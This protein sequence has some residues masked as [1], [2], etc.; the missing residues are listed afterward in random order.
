M[1]SVAK[2]ARPQRRRLV[3]EHL[4]HRVSDERPVVPQALQLIGM[5]QQRP[6][7]ECDEAHRRLEPGS[8][9]QDG[10]GDPLQ[11]AQPVAAVIRSHEC[12]E[13]IRVDPTRLLRY[14]RRKELGELG[15]GVDEPSAL[16][17]TGGVEEPDDLP[18]PGLDIDAEHDPH[19]F[20][21]QGERQGLDDVSPSPLDEGVHSIS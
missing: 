3:A 14:E 19:D 13:K 4:V 17:A 12:R 1:S 18:I 20:H 9:E 10:V 15:H 6:H 8:D 5:R 7:G 2:S 16:V 21:G 11:V